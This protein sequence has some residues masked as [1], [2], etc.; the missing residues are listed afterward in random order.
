[1]V[2]FEYKLINSH[3]NEKGLVESSPLIY[4]FIG[5][6]LKIT[7]L[8]SFPVSPSYLKQGIAYAVSCP[9]PAGRGKFLKGISLRLATLFIGDSK[10]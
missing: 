9:M 1:M 4:L 7:K 10:S 3:I 8:R 6:Y 5:V 2:I